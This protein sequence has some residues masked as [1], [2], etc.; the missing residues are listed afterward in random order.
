MASPY[1]AINILPDPSILDID[2]NVGDWPR[3]DKYADT[4][5][6]ETVSLVVLSKKYKVPGSEAVL[7]NQ[8]REICRAALIEVKKIE[9]FLNAT[10]S[11]VTLNAI[12][13]HGRIYTHTD[14]GDFFIKHHRVHLPLQTSA[15]AVMTVDDVEFHLE[16][17]VFCE[18]DNV[19]PHSVVNNSDE[20]RVHLIID[21]L[22]NETEFSNTVS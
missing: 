1:R 10:A 15:G 2:I 14:P 18:I 4:S 5:F 9:Q 16:R 3:V 17:G 20:Y 12:V 22:P 6:K 19:R 21:L 11:L 8:D 7:H 13:P